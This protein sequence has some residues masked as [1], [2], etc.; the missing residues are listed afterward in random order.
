MYTMRLKGSDETILS[1]INKRVQSVMSQKNALDDEKSECTSK[2]HD[3]LR[4]SLLGK[5]FLIKDKSRDCVES[6]YIRVK[7]VH[8][9]YLICNDTEVTCSL[10]CDVFGIRTRKVDGTT[11]TYISFSDLEHYYAHTTM[12]PVT[13]KQYDA[14]VGKYKALIK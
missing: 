8:A 12:E 4:K 10:A 14:I 13:Q 11:S 5:I 2:Y 7:E 6:R 1:R 3:E 9:P